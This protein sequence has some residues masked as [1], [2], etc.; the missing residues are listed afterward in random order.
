MD[1]DFFSQSLIARLW[2]ADG[3]PDGDESFVYRALTSDHSRRRSSD[4]TGF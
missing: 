1:L 4:L 2:L 3:D